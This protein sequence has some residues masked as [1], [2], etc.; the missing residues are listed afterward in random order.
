MFRTT[1]GLKKKGIVGGILAI[2]SLIIFSTGLASC[3]L[4]RVNPAGERQEE[5]EGYENPRRSDDDDDENNE[6]RNR[7]EDREDEEDDD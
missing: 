5:R 4:G 6:R 3:N 2:A 7:Q 1:E